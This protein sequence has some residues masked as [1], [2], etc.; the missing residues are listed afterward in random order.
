MKRLLKQLRALLLLGIQ[1]VIFQPL[2]RLRNIG[3]SGQSRFLAAY[4]P[5]RLLPLSRE[6]RESRD[7]FGACIHCGL[8]DTACDVLR[9]AKR[10]RVP[11]LSAVAVG[12]S[13]SMPEYPFALVSIEELSGC[14]DCDECEAACPMGVPLKE[15]IDD[16][17]AHARRLSEAGAAVGADAGLLSDPSPGSARVDVASNGPEEGR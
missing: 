3:R 1:A 12:Y 16:V 5:D 8:C 11:S 6:E 2:R 9:R 15:I 17:R 13:R 7:R 10:S 14:E 4:T